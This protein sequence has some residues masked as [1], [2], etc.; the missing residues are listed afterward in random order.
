MSNGGAGWA[1]AAA[2]VF[3]GFSARG[4]NRQQLRF[5]K[6]MSRTQHQREVADLRAAGLNPILS[7]M[8]GS[9]ASSQNP[10][11]HVPFENLG[12]DVGTA[13]K[14][15][16]ERRRINS[17][18][19]FNSSAGS[20]QRALAGAATAMQA[21]T[22]AQTQVTRER[23]PLRNVEAQVYT[24]VGGMLKNVTSSQGFLKLKKWLSAG[25]EKRPLIKVPKVPNLKN[26]LLSPLK[27]MKETR[28]KRDR[29][30]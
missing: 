10:Q 24:E 8:G 2:S 18:I 21:N 1:Q 23:L 25:G 4:V 14:V 15:S 28:K 26:L 13:V 9:G 5:A 29:R 20:N 16:Q 30:R 7:G 27:K 11:L 12:R 3:G 17:E 19:D 6:N 22:E